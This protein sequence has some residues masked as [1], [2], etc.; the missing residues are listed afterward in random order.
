VSNILKELGGSIIDAD[1]IAREIVKPGHHILRTIVKE[2]GPPVLNKDGTLNRKALG[3]IVFND[4]DKLNRLNSITHPEIK[5]V[6][7]QEIDSL[8]NINP[9]DIIIIDAAVL[10]ESGMDCL[11]DKVWLVY[12][13]PMTQLIRLMK[14]DCITEDE[15]IN[16]INS[17]LPIDKK[18]EIVKRLGGDIIYNTGDIED[19]KR[20]VASL[21]RLR[22]INME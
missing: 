12:T 17:Q 19:T 7:M 18:L 20:Q 2:F 22:C 21:W 16:R 1:I 8:K 13:E 4:K 10:L 15:A 14:R 11:C 3:K 6:I 9:N 5:K